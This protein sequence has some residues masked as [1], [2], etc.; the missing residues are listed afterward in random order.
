MMEA[1]VQAALEGAG[2]TGGLRVVV[3]VPEGEK[4][5][6]K[7]FNPNLGIEGGI[8]I[9][10]TSGIVRPMSEEAL[11]ASIRLDLQVHAAAGVKDIIV[12]PGNYGADFSRDV[13]GLDLSHS[14]QC[15]NYIGATIDMAVELGFRSFMLVGHVGK[16]AKVAAGVMNTHSRVADGRAEVLAAH[17]ALCGADREAVA[18]ILSSVTTD[19]IIPKLDEGGLREPVMASVSQAIDRQLKH[20][21][22][23]SLHIEALFFSNVY[24]I[25]GKTPGAEELLR[26][27]SFS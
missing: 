14:V 17:A 21:A 6:K 23:E 8:S 5:A 15:S 11:I 9:L 19:A 4:I 24:G 20:R 25:L 26:L 7:T 10:G 1:Q 27:Y 18:A 13:L 12:S 3:S 2:E 22:G 16:L